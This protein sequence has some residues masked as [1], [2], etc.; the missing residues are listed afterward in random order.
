MIKKIISGGQTGAERAALD[1][2]IQFNISHCGWIPK[3]RVTEAGRL[4]NKY[5]L[6]EMAAGSY[7]KSREQNVID[8]GG[9][10][11][12]SHGDLSAESKFIHEKVLEYNKQCLHIDL[13]KINAF[14]AAHVVK[15][16]VSDYSIEIL[17]VTGP[18]ISEDKYIYQA[19]M[20]LLTTLF[21]MEIIESGMRDPGSPSSLLPETIEGVTERLI[22]ELPLRD[23]VQ[24]A[25]MGDQELASLNTTLGSYIRNKY[26]WNG[27]EPLLMDCMYKI[28]KND[29]SE[30][31]ASTIIIHALWKQLKET[32]RLR[33]V[34]P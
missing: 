14:Q 19:T 8:S 28:G 24:I 13:E 18:N 3:G 23:K 6:T 31:E 34:K 9:T 16:W 11:I 25:R 5:K 22:D 10:L 33:I 7:T 26:L 15:K 32:H 12:I 29:I 2:A 27:N 17:N 4:P 20:R 1:A 21:H 30:S